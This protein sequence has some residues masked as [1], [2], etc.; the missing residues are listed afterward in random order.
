MRTYNEQVYMPYTLPR[1]RIVLRPTRHATAQAR[2][3]GF[4]I[5]GTLSLAECKLI[6]VTV[7][8]SGN[9][10]KWLVRTRYDAVHDICIVYLRT[11]LVKTAWLNARTDT[12]KT[13]VRSR[14]VQPPD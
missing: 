4:E 9:E 2:R 11:G 6:E 12:H 1:H 10:V 8:P 3:K 5:P 13:L 7:D 14:Y